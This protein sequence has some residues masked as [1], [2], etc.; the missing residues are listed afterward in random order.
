MKQIINKHLSFFMAHLL[1]SLVIFSPIQS[2]AQDRTIQVNATANFKPISAI[3]IIMTNNKV[4]QNP[5]SKFEQIS[6]EVTMLT[7]PYDINEVDSGSMVTAYLIGPQGE[8]AMGDVKLIT[9]AQSTKS[10]YSLPECKNEIKLPPGLTDQSGWVEKILN[11]RLARREAYQLLIGQILSGNFLQRLQKLEKGFGIE[12][13]TK[14]TAD[15]SAFE[16]VDR[17]SRIASAIKSYQT[18]KQKTE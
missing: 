3:G 12:R 9:S 14:L 5:V 10:F 17:L 15:L 4:L 2:F 18:S 13:T 7:I 6:E 16:L 8:I 11:V 1:L